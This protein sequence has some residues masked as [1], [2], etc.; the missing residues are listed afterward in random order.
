VWYLVQQGLAYGVG[1]MSLGHMTH[2]A[3][4]VQDYN[5]LAARVNPDKN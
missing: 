4:G 3:G 2:E 5:I 1:H